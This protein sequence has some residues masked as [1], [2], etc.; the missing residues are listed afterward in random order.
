ME[1]AFFVWLLVL[2]IP[3]LCWGLLYG[4]AAWRTIHTNTPATVWP[5]VAVVIAA[6]NEASNL[7]KFLPHVLQQDYPGKWSVWVVNDHAEDDTTEVIA[8]LS[9]DYPHLHLIQLPSG[10][11]G[12]KAALHAG[13]EACGAASIVVTDADC[14]PATSQWLRHM[15]QPLAQGCVG[16]VG[17]SPCETKHQGWLAAY[18][19]YEYAVMALLYLSAA[20]LG[21][22]YMAVGR[23]MAFSR[24]AYNTSGGL[25]ALPDILS[26]SDDLLLQQLATLGPV[27]IAPAREAWVYTP[28][29]T[30]WRSWWRQKRRHLSTG[31]YYK[32]AGRW[33]LGGWMVGLAGYFILLLM[34]GFQMG[35]WIVILVHLVRSALQIG[36][37]ER[38]SGKESRLVNYL[39]LPI[40]DILLVIYVICGIPLL[41]WKSIQTWK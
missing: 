25:S 4:W 34:I 38:W 10:L 23:N 13:I 21:K 29:Q 37:F 16:V 32:A 8:A 31:G 26:G 19:Q 41:R 33:W 24:E 22:P 30:N 36:I 15:V 35:W 11:R 1:A 3:V 9:G 5:D 20:S 39:W 17:F 12:K 28:P 40:L 27:G 6:R 2:G 18:Q 7:R 14:Y